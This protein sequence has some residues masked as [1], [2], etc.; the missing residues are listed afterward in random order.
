MIKPRRIKIK[1]WNIEDRLIKRVR[2]VDCVKSELFKEGHILLQYTGMEDQNDVEIYDGD[3][4][5]YQHR[6]YITSWDEESHQW[7][8]TDQTNQMVTKFILEEARQSL[9][10]CH[11]LESSEFS[12]ED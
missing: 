11:S 12:E 6:K 4:L 2:N 9:R 5:L 10:L 7:I 3:V 1:A 8:W